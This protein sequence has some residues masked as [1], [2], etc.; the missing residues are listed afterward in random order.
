MPSSCRSVP[1]CPRILQVLPARCSKP[2]QIAEP[3]QHFGNAAAQDEVGTLSLQADDPETVSSICAVLA[4]TDVINMVSRGISSQN[5]LKGIHLSMAGRL[6]KLLKA[7][8]VRDSTVLVTG[9]LARD[10]GLCRV[11]QKHASDQKLAVQIRTHTD[12]IF[13]GAIGA[14]IWGE[15]RYRKLNQA[16]A[17]PLAA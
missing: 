11:L 3:D 14:A 9:G 13:A 5:I 10:E 8:K 1:V 17:S 15:F 12:S 6:I 7:I 4:E 16:E 2:V